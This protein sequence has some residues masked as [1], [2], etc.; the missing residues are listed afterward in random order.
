M[1]D[2]ANMALVLDTLFAWNAHDPERMISYLHADHVLESDTL[3]EAVV[4]HQSYRD[5]MQMYLRAF[6]DLRFEITQLIP[7][8]RFVAERW[9]AMGTHLGE[10]M[11]IAATGRK[12]KTHGCSVYHIS[13]GK[14]LRSWTYW[15]TGSLLHQ[16][17]VLPRD[18][19]VGAR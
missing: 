18:E 8:G 11:G 14:I 4:G 15:D 6:P 5:F 19:A 1:T 2:K 9:T 16:L 13:E 12:T 3:P 17:G 7:N 10:L